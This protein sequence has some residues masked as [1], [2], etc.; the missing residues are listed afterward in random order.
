M[1]QSAAKII[2][3]DDYPP[4]ISGTPALQ[5]LQAHGDVTT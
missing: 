2:I 3:P 5:T 4:V 1:P